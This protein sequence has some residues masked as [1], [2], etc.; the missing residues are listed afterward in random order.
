MLQQQEDIDRNIA[1]IEEKIRHIKQ[2]QRKKW[3][4]ILTGNKKDKD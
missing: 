1:Q 3:I 2:E 4:K